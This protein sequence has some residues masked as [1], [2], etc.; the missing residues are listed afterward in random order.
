ML[1]TSEACP[2]LRAEKKEME[3]NLAYS[4]FWHHSPERLCWVLTHKVWQVD[5]HASALD[6]LTRAGE[7]KRKGKQFLH[8]P[9]PQSP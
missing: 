7:K 5:D 4:D 8:F 3:Q 6:V 1:F 9:E 2:D